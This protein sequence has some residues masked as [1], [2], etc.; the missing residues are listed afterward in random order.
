MPSPNSPSRGQEGPADPPAPVPEEDP[1][2]TEPMRDP[3]VYPERDAVGVEE[4]HEASGNYGVES[5]DPSPDSI[6]SAGI[7]E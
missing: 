6:V 7:E 4:I 2:E 1:H 3:P 5:P